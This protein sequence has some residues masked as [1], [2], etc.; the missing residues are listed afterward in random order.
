M[1][2]G[3]L[4]KKIVPFQD[5]YFTTATG[6]SIWELPKFARMGLLMFICQVS[7]TDSKMD[8]ADVSLLVESIPWYT[9]LSSDQ[10]L[11][12]FFVYRELYYPI[13][14]IPGS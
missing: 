6:R 10:N 5:D 11:G 13:P 8:F 3:H 7:G 9:H 2:H 4:K 1:S 14:I 12:Y